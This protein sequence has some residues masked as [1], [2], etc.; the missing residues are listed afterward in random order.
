[1]GRIWMKNYL[2]LM[3]TLARAHDRFSLLRR[4]LRLCRELTR[5]PRPLLRGCSLPF[6]LFLFSL[7]FSSFY[8]SASPTGQIRSIIKR[9]IIA[10]IVPGVSNGTAGTVDFRCPNRNN[11]IYDKHSSPRVPTAYRSAPK[12]L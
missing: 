5:Y 12:C 10:L 3:R 9:L 11:L 1:M 8:L 6:S 7:R 2:G 4:A